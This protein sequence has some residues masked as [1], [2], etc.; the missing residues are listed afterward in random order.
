MLLRKLIFILAVATVE[1]VNAQIPNSGMEVWDQ[2]PRLQQWVNNS[3]PLTLPP[4]DPYI[5]RKDAGAFSGQYAAN[6]IGNGV[7]KPI[8]TTKFSINNHPQNLSLYYKLVFPPC[9]NDT[10]FTEKDTVSIEVDILKNGLVVDSGRWQG[11][12][13]VYSYN[14]L[15]IPISQSST[16]YDSCKISIS[17]GRLLGGCGIIAASTQFWVDA[18]SLNYGQQGCVDSSQINL[19]VICPALYDPV[20]GCDGKTYDNSCSAE[21]YG[22]VTSWTQGICGI[23]ND[24]CGNT[25]VVI[26]GVECAL[27]Q[28]FQTGS[29]L[30]PCSL[31]A[32]AVLHVGDTVSYDYALTSCVSFCM[33]GINADFTCFHVLS[34][35]IATGTCQAEF[36]FQKY[37]DSVL[38]FSN[39]S[40]AQIT[41]YLWSFGD[42]SSSTLMSPTHVYA[43]PGW[44]EVCL[45]ISGKDSAGN[46]CTDS[47]CDSIYISDGCIDSS[48]ICP[49]GSLCCDAPLEMPVCGCDSVTYMNACVASLFGGV[50]SS[51]EGPCSSPTGIRSEKKDQSF[52]LWPNPTDEILFIS[53][54]SNTTQN[55]EI[56]FSD[57]QGR[58]I[59]RVEGPSTE[60]ISIP[61]GEFV[62]GLYVVELRISGNA[63][64]HKKLIVR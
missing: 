6:F 41:N 44:Y 56:L 64:A 18:L 42:N 8:A 10:G 28:D 3:Y 50:I 43:Q 31:P 32:G 54:N 30:M 22:G 40:A 14:Q 25:G 1:F 60:K 15:I 57:I 2:Q 21:N 39:S 16:N 63:V 55:A 24:T 9:V 51:Y 12:Q 58:V 5:I 47:Y 20:C 29:L 23:V 46:T 59:K 13:N 4:Y 33:Q 45:Y 26:Q 53:L 48:I 36:N 61:V 38:F 34:T 35:N 52:T 19:N 17:G 7:I 27:I 62:P 37:V 11:F 49:P